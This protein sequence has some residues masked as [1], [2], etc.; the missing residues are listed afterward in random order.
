[1][2]FWSFSKP[3]P[4]P[5]KPQRQIDSDPRWL[6]FQEPREGGG[7]LRASQVSRRKDPIHFFLWGSL[8]FKNL[9]YQYGVV[10]LVVCVLLMFTLSKLM[11]L[12]CAEVQ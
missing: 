9:T 5:Y 8:H 2:V 7:S 6:E 10:K 1:M 4:A 12:T 11:L 3:P